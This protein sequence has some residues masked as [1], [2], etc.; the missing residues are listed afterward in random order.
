MQEHLDANRDVTSS[1]KFER[2]IWKVCGIV[3]LFIAVLW[4]LKE[5]FNVLLLVLA[6]ALIA[7][8]FHALSNWINKK[9]KIAHGASMAMSVAVTVLVL[10]AL[11]YFSGARIQTQVAEL[12]KTLPNT[13]QD[14]KETLSQSYLGEAI[15]KTFTDS[16]TANKTSAYFETFFRSTFGIL[17]DLYVVLFLG[18]FFT[19]SPSMYINGFLK[20]FPPKAR[21]VT[22]HILDRLGYTLK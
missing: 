11:I 17:G 1:K 2:S 16:G 18:I 3:A 9:T 12:S 5:T 8:Y 13:I 10:T 20:L 22:E 4:I 7:V 14:V 6:G 19:I 21:V 15:L